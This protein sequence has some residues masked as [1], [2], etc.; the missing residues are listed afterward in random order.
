MPFGTR[1]FEAFYRVDQSRNR[2]TGGTGLGLYIIKRILDLHEAEI[3][4]ENIG[5]GVIVSAAAKHS[6]PVIWRFAVIDLTRKNEYNYGEVP[7]G[8]DKKERL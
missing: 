4:I 6:P 3:K 2:Q 7:G 1:R 5:Q 8:K